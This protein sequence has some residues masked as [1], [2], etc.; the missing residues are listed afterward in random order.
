MDPISVVGISGD[1]DRH[2]Q[3]LMGVIA[4][5]LS[6]PSGLGRVAAHKPA[7]DHVSVTTAPVREGG[8]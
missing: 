5:M 2:S 8:E 1:S 6:L 3:P 4:E 7:H